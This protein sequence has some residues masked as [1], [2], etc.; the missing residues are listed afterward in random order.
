MSLEPMKTPKAD[1]TFIINSSLLTKEKT[2]GYS[3]YKSLYLTI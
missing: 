1:K 2:K 3:V